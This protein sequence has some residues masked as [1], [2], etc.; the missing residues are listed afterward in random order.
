MIKGRFG[1]A[2]HLLYLECAGARKPTV[3]MDAG[4]GNTPETWQRVAPKLTKSSRVCIYNRANLGKSD[5]AP[6]PRTSAD[7]VADLTGLLKAAGISPPYL[8]VGHSFDGINVQLFA[9]TH[10][11]EVSGLVLVYSTPVTFLDDEC[12][13]VSTSLS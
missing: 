13:I 3:V 12:T 6:K 4:L 8:L 7:V 5:A 11:D 2:G 1:V 10:P 9:A